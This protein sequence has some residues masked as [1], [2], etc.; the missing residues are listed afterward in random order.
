M[1]FRIVFSKTVAET[2]KKS[3]SLLGIRVPDR[4]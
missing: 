4:M 1:R 3:M 2:L